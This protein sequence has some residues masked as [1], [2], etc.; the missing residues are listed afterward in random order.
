MAGDDWGKKTAMEMNFLCLPSPGLFAVSRFPCNDDYSEASQTRPEFDAACC[1]EK[2][3]HAEGRKK[4][5]K[6]TK[7]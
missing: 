5:K 6:K 4:K 7:K 1:E 2:H 3:A